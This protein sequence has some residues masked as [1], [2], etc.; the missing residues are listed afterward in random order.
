MG[1]TTKDR[2]NLD[3]APRIRNC[4]K[5]V[6]KKSPLEILD[7]EDVANFKTVASKLVPEF[8][9]RLVKQVKNETC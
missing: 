8:N 9:S 2:I 1:R 7:I 5:K 6:S 4:A 3:F